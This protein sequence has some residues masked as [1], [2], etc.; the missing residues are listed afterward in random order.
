MLFEKGSVALYAEVILEQILTLTCI[1]VGP[2]RP[3]FFE[4]L[5]S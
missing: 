1:G 4:K 5:I 3:T 2:K